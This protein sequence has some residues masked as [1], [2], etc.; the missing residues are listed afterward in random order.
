MNPQPIP[1]IEKEPICFTFADVVR[2]HREAR[3]W[4]PDELGVFTKLSG[5]MIKYVEARDQV[6]TID[7]GARISRAFG[8]PFSQ[9]IAE[10][11]R[12]LQL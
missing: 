12:R 6:P 2:V 4:T 1:R 3:G 8:V 7:T 11:E 9:L 5:Q 10:A